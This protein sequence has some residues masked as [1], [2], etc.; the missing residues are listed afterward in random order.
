MKPQTSPKGAITGFHALIA[1]VAFLI[2]TASSS[3]AIRP[4][5]V[6]ISPELGPVGQWVYVHGSGFIE[7]GTEVQLTP[8]VLIP[9]HVYSATQL[10]FRI[11]EGL[12]GSLK[13]RVKTAFGT[14]FEAAL[15]QIGV[16]TGPP[17][18]TRFSPQMGPVGQ[19]VYLFGENFV[20][21]QTSVQVA[22]IA[23]ESVLVY[24]PETAGFRLP[25]GAT[26]SVQIRVETPNGSAI[27]PE[28]FLVGSPSGVPRISD[29][30]EYEGHNWIY[31]SGEN[32]VH[33]ETRVEIDDYHAIATVYGPDSL[34]FE[35]RFGWRAGTRL[36]VETPF[37][38]SEYNLNEFVTDHG[39]WDLLF[40]TPS[41][42]SYIEWFG[43][44]YPHVSWVYH[45]DFQWMYAMA[46][47]TQSCMFF[48]SQRGAWLWTSDTLFPLV[49]AFEPL[50]RWI[51]LAV[52]D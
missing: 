6:R 46:S 25:A 23:A 8:S 12:S 33:G 21:G 3:G 40:R 35:P 9:A 32:F 44:F 19:W 17:Q 26:G 37:G 11:P 16:P 51:N 24:S 45:A 20:F 43:W 39:G 38:R 15:F 4:S 47:R 41:G 7:G 27:A 34:G 28:H 14:S 30:R 18:L 42:W 13:V 50:N 10:G 36:A 1:F 52:G 29:F 22:G 31:L 49:Y 2:F 5:I 48:C